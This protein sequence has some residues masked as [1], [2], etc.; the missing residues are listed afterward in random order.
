MEERFNLSEEIHN[1]K[2]GFLSVSK[3]KE[4]IKLLKYICDKND[5]YCDID[6]INRLAGEK[7]I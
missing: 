3:V 4:F 5:G 1:W 6:D 7:L 2:Y